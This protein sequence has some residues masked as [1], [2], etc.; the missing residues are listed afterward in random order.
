MTRNAVILDGA[1]QDFRDIK[2]PVKKKFIDLF[3]AEVN[4]ESKSAIKR[5]SSNLM[6]GTQIEETAQFGFG[7]YRMTLVPDGHPKLPHL[8][9][10]KLLH[11]GRSN[12]PFLPVCICLTGTA[13][14]PWLF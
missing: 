7:N 5:F 14:S 10:P 1:K 12:L 3:W 13:I 9:P 6:M 4:L 8:W 2:K 11:P